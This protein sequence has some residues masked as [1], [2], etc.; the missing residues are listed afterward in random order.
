ML[1]RK[2][3][4]FCEIQKVNVNH[5][6]VRENEKYPAVFWLYCIT[7]AQNTILWWWKVILIR[8]QTR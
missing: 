6:Q 7:H 3:F 1:C 8:I 5:H 2:L 4:F